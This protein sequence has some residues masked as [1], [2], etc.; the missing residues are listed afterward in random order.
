MPHASQQHG[1]L[2]GTCLMCCSCTHMQIRQGLT[3]PDITCI[4]SVSTGAVTVLLMAPASKMPRKLRLAD[5]PCCN[6]GCMNAA[7]L[8]ANPTDTRQAKCQHDRQNSQKAGRSGVHCRL[9]RVTRLPSTSLD[10]RYAAKNDLVS[11]QH[12]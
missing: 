2:G 8:W 1:R 10:M 9:L 7:E 5:M 11:D 6:L 3:F 4:R 12:N